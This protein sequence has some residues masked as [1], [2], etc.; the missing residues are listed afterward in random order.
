MSDPAI[1]PHL[2]VRDF[3]KSLAF[4]TDALG[5]EVAQ[6]FPR[7]DPKWAELA[8]ERS[9]LMI[10]SHNENP[11]VYEERRNEIMREVARRLD[12]GGAMTIYIRAK[13]V[14][15]RYERAKAGGAKIVFEPKDES[16]GLREFTL[17]TP[18]GLCLS[19]Y[20]LLKPPVEGSRPRLAAPHFFVR[21]LA[22]SVDYYRG[23]LGFEPEEKE[24]AESMVFCHVR[25]GDARMMLETLPDDGADDTSRR[26]AWARHVRARQGLPPA[27]TVYVGE[28]DVD[29]HFSRAKAAGGKILLEPADERWHLREY[30]IEDPDGFWI[31]FHQPL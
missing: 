22:K 25:K 20:D 10:S 29:A 18:E 5:F 13:N 3:S 8:L 21:D 4:F 17:E 27:M 24:P 14:N 6:T 1:T 11:Q 31:V 2:W 9:R 15:E 19:F 30:T 12:Q 16:Y 28:K 23:V 7:E 26:H